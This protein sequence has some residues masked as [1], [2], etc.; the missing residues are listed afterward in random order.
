MTKWYLIGEKGGKRRMVLA[1]GNRQMLE[2][3]GKVL[4]YRKG[5]SGM[6]IIP[7]IDFSVVQRNSE[8]KH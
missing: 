6:E 2:D 3:L 1:S 8:E 4:V 7:G 5:W